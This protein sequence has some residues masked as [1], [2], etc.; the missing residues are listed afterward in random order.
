MRRNLDKEVR[1]ARD[2]SMPRSTRPTSAIGHSSSP[3][4]RCRHTSPSDYVVD[5]DIP[6][7]PLKR[8]RVKGPTLEGHKRQTLR[9][10]Q[11]LDDEEEE[12]G[13]SWPQQQPPPVLPPALAVTAVALPTESITPSPPSLSAASS[14]TPDAKSLA[15][16][17]HALPGTMRTQGGART[18]S[19]LMLKQKTCNAD[20]SLA[21]DRDTVALQR[22]DAVADADLSA[23]LASLL[24]QL[25]A[26]NQDDG[27]CPP[28]DALA[29]E[30]RA[31]FSK[32]KQPFSLDSYIERVVDHVPSRPVLVTSLVLIDRLFNSNANL[33]LSDMNVH[34]IVIT[35]ILLASKFLE[36]EPYAQ[37]F[38]RQAGGVPSLEELN[39]LEAF[40]LQQLDWKIFVSRQLYSDYY[41]AVCDRMESMLAR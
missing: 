18:V 27:R 41:N 36:D 7:Q 30:E 19:T 31:F 3:R 33:A 8:V 32:Q 40:F 15:R 23:A 35:A 1:L 13:P 28:L 20:E 9:S 14:C 22:L 11:G 25:C 5:L 4:K 12:E 26:G 17:D 24:G 16:P 38:Y 2:A 37:E 21:T 39:Q 34:R 10:R 6:L 29:L